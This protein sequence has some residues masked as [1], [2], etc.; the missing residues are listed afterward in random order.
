MYTTTDTDT[1]DIHQSAPAACPCA[2]PPCP[3]ALAS[4]QL[5]MAGASSLGPA[6]PRSHK[7]KRSRPSHAQFPVGAH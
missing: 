1:Q 2:A 7:L 5:A 3:R 4:S 6:V